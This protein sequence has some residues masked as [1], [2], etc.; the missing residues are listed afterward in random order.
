VTSFT[1]LRS[2]L[3]S[4]DYEMAVRQVGRPLKDAELKASAFPDHR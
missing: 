3:D 1:N 2:A 4:L